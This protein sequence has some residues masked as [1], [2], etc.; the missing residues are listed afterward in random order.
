MEK[1]KKSLAF[2]DLPLYTTYVH[3][4]KTAAANVGA[5]DLSQA[6]YALEIAGNDE[7][8]GYIEAYNEDFL[9]SLQTILN[10]IQSVL[11]AESKK[12]EGSHL[13]RDLFN[14]ELEKL[15][16]ALGNMDAGTMDS[17]V[18]TLKAMPLPEDAAATVRKISNSI[19]MAEYD[20]AAALM[21]AL[22]KQEG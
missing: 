10:S 7:N 1:I 17:I 16:T 18:D 15:K 2:G 14:A 13:N 8:A 19:L 9:K 4:L 6:A 20:E 22:L 3:A 12:E 5:D 11:S 21:E